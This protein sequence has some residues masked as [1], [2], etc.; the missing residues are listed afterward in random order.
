MVEIVRLTKKTDRVKAKALFAM[1][2][3]VFDEA[4]DRNG[5]PALGD[6]YVDSLLARTDFWVFAAFSGTEVVG[7]ITAHTLPM[8]R[9]ESSEIFI[10]DVAVREDHQR[11]GIGRL[12]LGALRDA[13]NAAG[14]DNVFVAADNE[15]EHALDFY[16]ALGGSAAAV[17]MFTFV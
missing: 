15:D 9:S 11:R 5:K 12:L 7:G 8:T 4:E 10:Y 1:M 16:R 13:A 14:I 17:T 6:A 2:A 3:A